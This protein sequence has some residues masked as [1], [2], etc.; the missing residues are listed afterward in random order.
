MAKALAVLPLLI[1][2]PLAKAEVPTTFPVTGEIKAEQFDRSQIDDEN[3][4]KRRASAKSVPIDQA[5]RCI[6]FTYGA[7]TLSYEDRESWKDHLKYFY[8]MSISDVHK[9][10]EKAERDMKTILAKTDVTW[11]DVHRTYFRECGGYWKI[12]E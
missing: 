6:A 11:K 4:P 7:N 3:E 2:L 10:S 1:F 12:T 9:I 5:M 8:G